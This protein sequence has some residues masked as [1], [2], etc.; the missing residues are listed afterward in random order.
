VS[1]EWLL[2][3]EIDDTACGGNGDTDDYSIT[4]TEDGTGL[5]V[6][7]PNG[8]FTGTISGSKVSWTGQYYSSEDKGWVTIKSLSVTVS[9]D[10][11][12]GT[13]NWDFRQTK[14]GAIVCS[15]TTHVSGTRVSGGSDTTPPTV[16]STSPGSGATGA[17]VN[18]SVA[19]TFSETMDASTISIATFTLEDSG[20]NPVSGTVSYSGTTATFKPTVNLAHS[21]TYTATI[22]TGVKDSA[23]NA[24]TSNY[25]WGFTTGA[26]SDTTPPTVSSTS[27]A[28]NA[29]GVAVNNAVTAAFS[30]AMDATTITTTTFTLKQGITVV[31][32]SVTYSGTTATFTPANTL[33]HGTTYTATITTGVKDSAGNAMTSN[34]T[35]GFT[36]GA[37]SDTTPPTVS[38]TSPADSATGVAAN[39]A[40]TAAFSE[41]MD[42]ST[43][44][45]ATFTL[46]QGITVVPGSVTYSGTTATFTP[47]NTLAHGTTYTATITTGVKDS[48]G[49]AMTSNYPWSFTTGAASDTIPPSAPTSLTATEAGSSQINLSWSASTDSGGSG[50]AGYK[51]ERCSGVGCSTFTDEITTTT[52]ITYNNTGLTASTSYTYRVRAYDNAGNNSGYSN[53]ASATTQPAGDTQPPMTPANLTAAAASNQI[54]LTWTTSNDNVGVT[55][56]RVERCQGAGCG[57][58]NQIATPT[59]TSYSDT[60]VTAGISYSY[61]VR[62]VDAANNFSGYSNTATATIQTI[63]PVAPGNLQALNITTSSVTLTWTDNSNNEDRFDIGT[64]TPLYPF[65]YLWAQWGSAP[66]N[67]TT[68]TVTNLSPASSYTFYVRASNSAGSASSPGVPFTTASPP[69]TT[70]ATTVYATYDNVLIK[71][72]MDSSWE[73]TTYSNSDL[74]VGCNYEYWPYSTSYMCF[75]SAIYFDLP[76]IAGKTIDRA[77]LRLY[78]RVLPADWN[79]FYVLYAYRAT[80]NPSTITFNNSPFYST[81]GSVQINPPVTGVIPMEFDVTIIV[82]KWASGEWLNYGFKLQD[83]NVAWP[84]YTAYRAT[85]IES[86]EFNSSTDRSPQ[87]YLEYR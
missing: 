19:A 68:Y 15:G 20:G 67:T 31:P 83:G 45:T 70:T 8:I 74:A 53:T 66:A 82:Q 58:F 50:L 62:A 26:A 2:H 33:A 84:G 6:D 42:A 46:K 80:W 23:G 47:A 16:S 75:A 12:S 38:S 41:A 57:N 29:T 69:P 13:A 34:Y 55:G 3:E 87:L 22:T 35:W 65:G 40:V 18:T 85:Y 81:T 11:L 44:T 64:H 77:V 21:T 48:A 9:G 61:R 5:S 30:E 7:T 72:S 14:E 79:T 59:L 51:I 1:G 36:T 39:S 60:A 37:A 49:N 76:Q 63:V 56:Y 10:S 25:T 71:T 54:N 86:I 32:G 28:A 4:V 43:I 78:P 24:M 52:A 17:A 73:N 27:P